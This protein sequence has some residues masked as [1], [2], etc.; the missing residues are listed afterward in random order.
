MVNKNQ[1]EWDIVSLAEQV[2][3]ELL[4][5]MPALKTVDQKEKRLIIFDAIATC[6]PTS[7]AEKLKAV[8]CDDSSF[9]DLRSGWIE[10]SGTGSSIDGNLFP[11]MLV[12]SIIEG[13]SAKSI[14]DKARAFANSRMSMTETYAPLAGATVAEVVSLVDDI[15]LVPWAEVPDS[16]QKTY[17]GPSSPRR[18]PPQWLPTANSAIR[19]R[20]A[21]CQALFSSYEDADAKKAAEINISTQ[22]AKIDDVM[23]CII[24]Q[25]EHPIQVIGYWTQFDKK[26]ANEMIGSSYNTVPIDGTKVD[27][28][29]PIALDGESIAGLFHNFVDFKPSEKN[30]IRISLDRLYQALSERNL[31]DKAIDLGIALE[32]LLLHGTGDNDRGELKYR[33]SIRGAAFLGGNHQERMQTYNNLK[34]AY[35]L[36]SKAVHSGNLSSKKKEKNKRE[37]P[38]ETLRK[39]TDTC[40]RLAR[41]LINRGSFPNWEDEYVIGG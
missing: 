10:C 31:V 30:V 39:A 32:V 6:S 18:L 4:E 8:F 34:T 33:S 9:G 29:P 38:H 40:A 13:H 28:S 16:S 21:K 24:A 7:S 1:S 11:S 14:V 35:D 17:F 3:R 20:A 23:R 36:R 37:T 41:E 22:I 19:I 12:E 5:A 2:A 15:S 27:I 26:I 25:S